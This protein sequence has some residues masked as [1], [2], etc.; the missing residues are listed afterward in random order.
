MRSATSTELPEEAERPPADLLAAHLAA[1]ERLATSADRP[2]A[3]R[4]YAGEEGEPLA[5]HLAD[6]AEA[7]ADAPPDRTGGVAGA[8]RRPARGAARPSV[9][10]VRGRGGDPHPRVA[11]LGLLEARLGSFDRVVLAGLEEGYGRAAPTPARG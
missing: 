7:L 3:L 1:A 2:G 11:I 9:R 10:A 6:L 5:R 4:L 8:V